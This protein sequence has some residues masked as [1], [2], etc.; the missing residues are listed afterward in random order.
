MI[1]PIS[2]NFKTLCNEMG[3]SEDATKELHQLEK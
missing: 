1:A 3:L 2:E